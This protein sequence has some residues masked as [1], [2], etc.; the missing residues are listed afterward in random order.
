MFT[1][2]LFIYLLYISPLFFRFNVFH[3]AVFKILAA[4]T[5]QFLF[6]DI[7]F[8]EL[9]FTKL[10]DVLPTWVLSWIKDTLGELSFG[11]PAAHK[12]DPVNSKMG[13]IRG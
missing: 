4:V 10:Y 1:W 9:L 12:D 13:Q 2:S 5:F 7:D 11:L 6:L 3:E 8:Q